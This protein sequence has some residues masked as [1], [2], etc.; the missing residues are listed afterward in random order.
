VLHYR[1]FNTAGLNKWVNFWFQDELEKL[2]Q[3]GYNVCNVKPLVLVDIDTLIFN[4]DVFKGRDLTLEEVLIYYQENY[5]NFT[6]QGRKYRSE[7]EATQ[8]SKNSLIPFGD[9]L[10]DKVDS[11]G[12]R[13][14]PEEFE[15]KAYGLFDEPDE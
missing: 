8:A 12:L 9:Y 1:I 11:E 10:D 13:V 3:E 15:E 2:K 5:I 14:I 4:K 7:E 6:V